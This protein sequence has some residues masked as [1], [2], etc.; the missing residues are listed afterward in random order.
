MKNRKLHKIKLLILGLLI[1]TSQ[2]SYSQQRSGQEDSEKIKIIF[3]SDFGPDY[4]DAGALTFLH[5]MA[6]SGKVEILATVLCNKY[7]R[8][9]PGMDAMNTYY[10]RPDLP[11]GAPKTS[12]AKNLSDWQKWLDHLGAN[13][14]RD[15]TSTDNVPDA[16]AVYRQVLSEQPDASVTVVTVGFLTNLANLLQS[17]PDAISSLTGQELVAQKVKK[18]VSMAGYFPSGGEYNVYTDP[19]AS[20]YAFE[21]WPT[22]II[23]T[24]GEVGSM[25]RTGL[26]LIASDLVNHPCK[27]VYSICIPK[28]ADDVSGRPSW[29]QTA[30]LIAVYGIEPFFT[31]VS[32]RIVISADGKT[33]SWTTD[34]NGPHQYVKLNVK[35]SIVET[36]IEDR[37]MHESING[38]NP[39]EQLFGGGAGT[40]SDPYQ[41]STVE[42][43]EELATAV[44]G[45]N[46]FPGAHFILTDNI[47]LIYSDWQPINNFNGIFHGN[48]K[49]I[50]NLTI[51][52]PSDDN[53]GL[54][55]ILGGRVE[56][57]ALI[58]VNITA[59][60][61]AGALAGRIDAG[62]VSEVYASGAVNV[63]TERAGGL[64][65]F[66]NGG[67]ITNSISE[68]DVT[69]NQMIGGVVGRQ[70]W[71]SSITKC[72]ATGSVLWDGS[73]SGA[74]YGAYIGGI[75]GGQWSGNPAISQ[76]CVPINSKVKADT[77]GYGRVR[78]RGENGTNNSLNNYCWDG[79]IWEVSGAE[80][81]GTRGPLETLKMDTTY[82]S[83]TWDISTSLDPT[84]VWYIKNG[85]SLPVFQWQAGTGTSIANIYAAHPLRAVATAGGLRISGLTA[86]EDLRLYNTLG[87][88]LYHAKAKAGEQLIS[89]SKRGLYIAITKGK[90]LK[91]LFSGNTIL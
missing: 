42:H 16:V 88:L 85:E 44:N 56:K 54:F 80:P 9:A 79:T 76:Y 84:K 32:G 24:G 59:N 57:L 11:M 2:I 72:Y 48:G 62:N 89:I 29:D 65:G 1:F 14:P 47:D 51:N 7:W 33:N 30:V 36:F 10:G 46:S 58:N 43:L 66:L 68:V 78:G 52:R 90:S 3:D 64:V 82:A 60:S 19:A 71:N 53:Q 27:D 31:T 77:W 83:L 22:P 81:G 5:A 50:K 49:A 26:R 25:I 70:E 34:P 55:G 18:L 91:V 17:A 86:G 67:H 13:Y 41:I 15:I 12:G 38:T 6:D 61:R 4:D 21:N 23:F 74:Y 8:C 63:T 20:K 75:V 69:G 37:M 28:S 39:P 40:E 35:R 45:G 73:T 87:Q